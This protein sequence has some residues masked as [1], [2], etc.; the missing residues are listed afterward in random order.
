MNDGVGNGVEKAEGS[1]IMQVSLVKRSRIIII[2]LVVV[3][4]LILIIGGIILS[5]MSSTSYETNITNMEVTTQQSSGVTTTNY[6]PVLADNVDW[7]SLSDAARAGTARY[8]VN[9]AID[10]ANT[11]GVTSYSVLGMTD[12]DRTAVFFYSGGADTVT[13]FVGGESTS[14]PL[15]G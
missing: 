4:V 5:R 6:V 7:G 11:N 14:I 15:D 9:Q 13:L 8:A 12:A 1:Y 10:Q 3:V 2:A